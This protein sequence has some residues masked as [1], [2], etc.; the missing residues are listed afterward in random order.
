M[1]TFF[2]WN[3]TKDILKAI[4]S[5]KTDSVSLGNARLSF[6]CTPVFKFLPGGCVYSGILKKQVWFYFL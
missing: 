6:P 3:D 1:Q 2:F 5:G 4:A